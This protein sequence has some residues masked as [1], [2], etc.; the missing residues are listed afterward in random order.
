MESIN[1][2][3]HEKTN[4]K[5]KFIAC[6]ITDDFFKR[7]FTDDALDHIEGEI[8]EIQLTSK[9]FLTD[10]FERLNE[11]LETTGITSQNQR[12]IRSIVRESLRETVVRNLRQAGLN[13]DADT[14]DNCEREDIYL[15]CK[16]CSLLRVVQNHCDRHI[17]PLCQPR[18]ARKRADQLALWAKSI[19]Q[20]SGNV[21]L[22]AP[23]S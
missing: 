8:K 23:D 3:Y 12:Q 19:H 10:L 22:R 13:T 11:K 16:G 1:T 21:S 20:P 9:Q 4:D 7:N 14:I 2:F 18:L 5:K 17:C 15:V 6:Y